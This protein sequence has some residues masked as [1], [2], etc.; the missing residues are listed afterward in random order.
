MVVVIMLVLGCYPI[1][2]TST[3]ILGLPSTPISTLYRIGYLLITIMVLFIEFPRLS[4]RKIPT[5]LIAIVFFWIVYGIRL[6]HDFYVVGLDYGY[7]RKG[8]AY[9]FQYG[10]GGA[11]MP[12][13]GVAMLQDRINWKM[14]RT[15]TRQ[16]FFVS[17]F[18]ILAYIVFTQGFDISI[19]IQRVRLGEEDVIG[20]ILM[21]QTGGALLILVLIE[22]VIHRKKNTVL[23]LQGA[24]GVLLLVMGGSRGPLIATGLISS[25]LAFR[26][27]KWNIFR[28]TFWLQVALV[29]LALILIGIFIVLPNLDKI[30][31]FKRLDQTVNRGA[32]L[33]ERGLQWSSAWQQ[34]LDNPVAGDQI[35]E[36]ALNYYPHNFIL[37][38]LM[39]TGMI[40]FF[41]VAYALFIVSV[42][43]VN[44]NSIGIDRWWTY[45]FFGL[46]F[47]YACFSLPLVNLTQL[48]VLMAASGAHPYLSRVRN[49]C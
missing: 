23:I 33:S 30:A 19:F 1:V 17:C 15:L 41:F 25:S 47:L 4:S 11:L 2:G 37:E 42:K 9:F 29:C 24:V 40:G 26:S 35:I 16:S 13:I 18:F 36:Q 39:S 12:A 10:F 14:A 6:Y 34:F 20:P 27:F 46:F 7:A 48:W 5:V 45:Y 31:L 21:S 28:F 43:F 22:L 49:T 3:V 32:G 8:P 38:V 44:R